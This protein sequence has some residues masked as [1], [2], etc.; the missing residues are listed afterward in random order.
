MLQSLYT[1]DTTSGSV[2]EEEVSSVLSVHSGLD[3]ISTICVASIADHLTDIIPAENEAF[4]SMSLADLQSR[5]AI[6]FSDPVLGRV[7]YFIKRQWRLSRREH[8]SEF[9]QTLK[10]LKQ[11]DK[12][13]PPNNI[14]YHVTKDPMTKNKCSQFV[15]PEAL[16]P[17]LLAGIHDNALS[18]RAAKDS[19]LA[20]QR[21]FWND[22]E[23]TIHAYVRTSNR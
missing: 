21:F 1:S 9:N 19:C 6:P 4:Q 23:R 17:V 16:K 14:L 2:T 20:H 15:V 7:M 3:C 13:K 12:L 11:W 22:M 18:L 8:S 10:I 5:S